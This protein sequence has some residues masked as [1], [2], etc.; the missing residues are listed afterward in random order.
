MT[1]S[2]FIRGFLGLFPDA[3]YDPASVALLSGIVDS[4]KDG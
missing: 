4:S 1:A 2:D 3:N